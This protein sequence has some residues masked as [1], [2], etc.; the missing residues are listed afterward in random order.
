V[1]TPKS[2]VDVVESYKDKLNNNEKSTLLKLGKQWNSVIKNLNNDYI[3]VA[4]KASELSESGQAVPIQY[5]Y[6]MKQYQYLLEQA[7]IQLDGYSKSAE[8]IISASQRD[9]LLLGIDGANEATKALVGTSVKWNILNVKAYETMIGMSSTGAPLYEL[10]KT[11]YGDMAK[12]I[13]EA[14]QIGIVRGQGVNELVKNMMSAADISFKRSTLIARTEINRAY[15][16]A[17]VEQYRLS[18]VVKGFRRYCYKPTACLACLMMDGEFYPINREL[19]DH[20]NGKCTMIPVLYNGDD[21]ISWQTGREWFES[22]DPEEQERIMGSSLFMLW[23]DYGVPLES[24]VYMRDAGVWGKEPAIKSLNQLGFY[25]FKI[26]SGQLVGTTGYKAFRSQEEAD[27]ALR[28]IT[29]ALWDML[30]PDE[31]NA[32]WGYT[33]GSG[34]YN[35]PLRGLEKDEYDDTVFKG[36]GNVPLDAEYVENKSVRNPNYVENM[37][38]ALMK[39]SGYSENLIMQRGI[40]EEGAAALFGIDEYYFSK[41]S[42]VD[43]LREL[44]VGNKYK[45]T[46]FFSCGTMPGT[47]FIHEP[48]LLTVKVPAGTKMIYAEPFSYFGELGDKGENWNGEKA[49]TFSTEF[50]TILADGYTYKVE[51]VNFSKEKNKW[52]IAIE[53]IKDERKGYFE[54][55]KEEMD[56]LNKAKGL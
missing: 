2:V 30:T 19:T 47:G 6:G 31:K 23:K 12:G 40:D 48:V 45:D 16:M 4:Q 24:M 8:N 54:M 50:E 14:L 20:P 7:N 13:A 22:L 3:A 43:E 56:A 38:N 53:V 15:R 36:I 28:P 35:R 44:L 41:G 1:K 18:G 9:S 46:A 11:S 32:L 27:A 55:T 49:R 42:N 51:N 37:H 39:S 34:K 25:D 52:E 33:Q 29:K 17:S 21:T 26:K 10:L 5:I